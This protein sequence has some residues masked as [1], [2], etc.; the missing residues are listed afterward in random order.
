M[1]LSILSY[2]STEE[3][4]ATCDA[5]F[6]EAKVKAIIFGIGRKVFKDDR[7]IRRLLPLKLKLVSM[8]RDQSDK[9]NTKKVTETMTE[10]ADTPKNDMSA[11][12]ET[13]E[14]EKEIETEAEAEITITREEMEEVRKYRRLQ[15]KREL[16]EEEKA[17]LDKERE[18][19]NQLI[20]K[21]DWNNLREVFFNLDYNLNTY[22]FTPEE[23][24][25]L[26]GEALGRYSQTDMKLNESKRYASELFEE[27]KRIKEKYK[28]CE[29]CDEKAVRDWGKHEGKTIR[30]CKKDLNRMIRLNR[31]MGPILDKSLAAA[32][33]FIAKERR[34]KK[35]RSQ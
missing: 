23:W 30:Y 26:F 24:R 14:K 7:Q 13:T 9:K 29:V 32:G 11:I 27:V 5:K 17:L 1:D 2:L 10:L 28:I 33:Q 31:D 22:N 3:A 12:T 16:N 6:M 21:I 25:I 8:I 19:K 20:N 34:K 15:Y 18:W 4:A 35:I